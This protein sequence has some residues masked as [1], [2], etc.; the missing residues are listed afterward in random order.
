VRAHVRQIV[1]QCIDAMAPGGGFILAA[2]HPAQPDV[3][4]ADF[5]VLCRAAV[6]DSEGIC[7]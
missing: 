5:I 4:P 3:D 2:T 7:A 1:R 6:T